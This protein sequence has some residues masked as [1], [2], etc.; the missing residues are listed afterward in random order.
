MRKV[1]EKRENY[2]RLLGLNPFKDSDESEQHIR[3]HIEKAEAEW[4]K[5]QTS[6][7]LTKKQ[8][9]LIG[10]YLKLVPDIRC[11]M[12]SPILR[13]EEFEAARDILRRKS[14]KLRGEAIIVQ[15]GGVF[16]S[17]NVADEFAKKLN[18][19][20]LDGKTLILASG[21]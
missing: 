18:W 14:S 2:C 17:P 15:D 21:I 11:T 4:I 13:R 3:E 5:E 10:E 6:P 7:T 1:S 9:Y 16:I 20:G 8:K 12:D 19:K